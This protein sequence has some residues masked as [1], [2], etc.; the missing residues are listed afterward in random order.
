MRVGSRSPVWARLV[1]VGER[2]LSHSHGE[3]SHL[4]TLAASVASNPSYIQSMLATQPLAPPYRSY[5]SVLNRPL[6]YALHAVS[7]TSTGT[8]ASMS[9]VSCAT[10]AGKS[11]AMF[12]RGQ[13]RNYVGISRAEAQP[14]SAYTSATNSPKLV[15]VG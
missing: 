4:A 10:T 9:A 15:R 7:A 11:C 1:V 8:S 12:L 14:G 6:T 5:H 3:P 13:Q 2:T